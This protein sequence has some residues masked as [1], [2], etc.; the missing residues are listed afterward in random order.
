MKALLNSGPRGLRWLGIIAFLLAV[1]SAGPPTARSQVRGALAAGRLGPGEDVPADV[2]LQTGHTAA[3]T[4][5]LFSPQGAPL[6]SAGQDQ[7]VRLWDPQNGIELYC[8]KH[9]A[10]VLAIAFSPDGSLLASGAEDGSI[11]LWE[12]SSGKQVKALRGHREPVVALAFSSDG[13]RLLSGGRSSLEGS[14]SVRLWDVARGREW[15][16]IAPEIFGLTGVFFGPGNGAVS[17]ASVEGDMEIRGTIR[18]FDA[19]TGAL[20]ATRAAI[21]RAASG[22]GRWLALQE[23]SS[24][25]TNLIGTSAGSA[26]QPLGVK[27]GAVAF[28]PQADWA[29]Y[30]DIARSAF[31][32]QTTRGDR[33][34]EPIPGYDGTTGL[35]AL[36]A[37]GS[38][39]AASGIGSGIQI[40]DTASGRRIHSLTAQLG[41]IAAVAFSPDERQI[42][43]GAQGAGEGALRL[44]DLRSGKE[45]LGPSTHEPVI[46]AAFSPD[47]RY[48]A[49]GS[50]TM[51][52]WDVASRTLVREWKGR[53]AATTAPAF[54]P[55]GK[56]LAG[57]SGGVV[58]VWDVATGAELRS[59]GEPNLYDSGALAWSPDGRLIAASAGP[60]AIKI[61]AVDSGRTLLTFSISGNV[62]SLAFS[63]SGLWLAAGSRAPLR[64]Q[65][66][67]GGGG[68]IAPSGGQRASVAA[69]DLSNGARLFAA[70]AGDWVSTVAFSRDGRFVLAA[71]G[72]WNAAG[73]VKLF[74][75]ASG[76]EARTLVEK[77][78]ASGA[79]AFS[80]QRDWLAA[81][82]S[83]NTGAVKLWKLPEA[84]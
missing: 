31:H 47:G 69:W 43:A 19:A 68:R 26:A 54:S 14:G 83:G 57:S 52:L 36:S 18:T 62:S 25:A 80:P 56:R 67:A 13:G 30:G 55:D 15:R 65:P 78:D 63:P 49:A 40:W 23:Q 81:G 1:V 2:V 35:L 39:L 64:F 60:G 73:A 79:A 11:T 12:T 3:V 66:S 32:V 10:A 16:T 17:V 50:R 82:A 77:I 20:L 24:S 59:F 33:V 34:L 84:R 53:F 5:L 44:W 51:Q 41:G 28:S 7:T 46:G 61:Y 9:P 71:L 4:A 72:E 21:L 70:E 22:D 8:F 75:V 48:L 42:V 38:L 6:A 58:S 27:I 74:E 37:G 76:R 29:A 45:M